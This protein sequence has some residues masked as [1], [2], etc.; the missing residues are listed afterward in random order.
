MNHYFTEAEL[1]TVEGTHQEGLTL[2]Q[3]LELFQTRGL[4]LSE[5]TVRK[6]VQLGLIDRS[7]RV[8]EKGRHRGSRGVYPVDSIRRINEIKQL[9]A[10]DLTL[11]QIQS[12][13]SFRRHQ[14]RGVLGQLRDL[15]QQLEEALENQA[16]ERGAE[17][18]H[19]EV[20]ALS[21][22]LRKLTGHVEKVEKLVAAQRGMVHIPQP[23]G[24]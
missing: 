9:L 17:A 22:T 3:I 20:Q 24:G 19:K 18:L 2:V 13:L 21:Q 23:H 7:K 12:L 11:A 5:A 10:Q 6:Y 14:V 15:H 8:G 1:R 16:E 4:K